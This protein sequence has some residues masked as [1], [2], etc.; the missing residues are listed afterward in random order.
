VA[1][2]ADLEGLE[3]RHPPTKTLAVVVAAGLAAA[4]LAVLPSPAVAQLRQHRSDQAA[5]ERTAQQVDSL[6]RQAAAQARPGEDPAAR[7]ALVKE[8][9]KAASAARNAPDP[10]SAVAALSQAQQN[11]KQLQDPNLR[12]KQDAASQAGQALQQNPQAAKAG[13]ALAQGDL[14]TGSQE[15][16]NL[17]QQLPSMSQQQQQ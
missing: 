17:A 4:L 13:N 12:S 15:L 9:Q 11:L 8:L 5:Q 10:Q 3:P 1:G 14:K 7:Q 2:R 6:A 16:K